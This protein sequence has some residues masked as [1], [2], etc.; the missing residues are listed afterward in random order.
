MRAILLACVCA[1]AGQGAAAQP[2]RGVVQA[3]H[4]A[5]LSAEIA[6]RVTALP[7]R[8]GDAFAKGD[9]LVRFDCAIFEAQR[10]KVSAELQAARDRLENDLQLE[11]VQSIGVL[12][13]KLSETAVRQAEAELR[14]ATLNTDRCVV[15]APWN[16]RVVQRMISEH[17]SARLNQELL[18]IVS[19]EALEVT[20]IVPAQWVRTLKPNQSFTFRVDETGTNH[21]ATVI[22]LGSTVDPVSQT[23]SVRARLAADPRLLPGMSGTASLR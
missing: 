6:A 8:A 23:L 2:V 18:S 21:A 4:Q 19:T 13:V 22:S 20:A 1:L 3:V 14:M 16:G 10:D 7:L 5:T 17:E 9:V 11:A 12:D 15:A